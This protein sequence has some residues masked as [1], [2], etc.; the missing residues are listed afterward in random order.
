MENSQINSSKEKLNLEEIGKKIQELKE[1][2]YSN[3]YKEKNLCDIKI[4]GKWTVGAIVKKNDEKLL[5]LDYLL[6][7][8]K[9][10]FLI[11][12]KDNITYFRKK[13]K[14]SSK[15]RKC[16]R[17]DEEILKKYNDY[18]EDFININFGK[19]KK[20]EKNKNNIFKNI[21]PID[22]IIILRGKLYYISDEVLCYSEVNNKIGINLS[23]KYIQNSLM[24]IKLFFD[25]SKENNEIILQYKQFKKTDYE[26]IILLDE[27]YAIISF[28]KDSLTLLKRIFGHSY[29]FV[30]FYNKYNDLIIKIIDDENSILYSKDIKIENI[31]Q[32]NSYYK[33][34]YF[35]I[36]KFKIPSK[37]IAFF[38]DYFYSINGFDSLTNLIISNNNF[39]FKFLRKLTSIFVFISCL[40]GNFTKKLNDNIETIRNYID[41][42]INN[43]REEDIKNN[44]KEEIFLVLNRIYEFLNIDEIEK[45]KKFENTYL[46]YLYKCIY[47]NILEKQI[48]SIKT[49][50]SIALTIKYN[51]SNNENEVKDLTEIKDP[52]IKLLNEVEFA[53]FISSKQIINFLL[54]EKI[55]EEIIKNSFNLIL[56]SYKNNFSFNQEEYSDIIDEKAKTIFDSLYHKML[57][58]KN[59][60][61]VIQDLFCKLAPYLNNEHKLFIFHNIKEFIFN[62]EINLNII[63]FLDKFTYKCLIN[64]NNDSDNNFYMNLDENYFG[65]KL[66]WNFMQ[67]EYKNKIN[68]NTLFLEIINLCIKSIK[69]ILEINSLIDL[70]REDII[71]SSLEKISSHIGSTQNIILIKEIIS[72][73]NFFLNYNLILEKITLNTNI[74]SIIISDLLYYYEKEE[75]DK[76]KNNNIYNDEEIIKAH[77]SLIIELMNKKRELNWEF[78]KFLELWNKTSKNKLYSNIFYSNLAEQFPNIKTIFKDKIYKKIICNDNLFTIETNE[79]LELYKKFFYGINLNQDN[80]IILNKDLRIGINDLNSIIGYEKLWETLINNK[81]FDVQ[82][83]ISNLLYQICIGYKFPKKEEAKDYFNSFI[84]KLILNLKKIIDNERDENKIKGILNLVK[85]INENK[86]NEG[87]LIKKESNLPKL[88][89]EKNKDN[90]FIRIYFHYSGFKTLIKVYHYYPIYYIR[91]KVSLIYNIYP[92]IIKFK[93]ENLENKTKNI[94]EFDLC[95][96]FYLFN[97][98]IFKDMKIDYD[99]FYNIIVLKSNNPFDNIENNPKKILNKNKEFHK[100]LI[101]LSKDKDKIYS[102]DVWDLL[103]DKIEK[104]YALKDLIF[105]I[106]NE[107]NEQFENELNSIFDFNTSIFYISYILINIKKVLENEKK[108]NNELFIIN[109]V[110]SKIYIGKFNSMIKNYSLNEYFQNEINYSIKVYALNTLFY[111]L[112]IF[113]IFLSIDNDELNNLINIKIIQFIFEIFDSKIEENSL[114]PYLYDKECEIF[115]KICEL[116]KNNKFL[117]INFISEI[118]IDDKIKDT[119]L[120]LLENNLIQNKNKIITNKFKEFILIILNESWYINE[121][122]KNK[123]KDFN[124]LLNKVFLSEDNLNKKY[125]LSY[126]TE[127]YNFNIYFEIINKIILISIDLKLDFNYES[128]I[129]DKILSSIIENKNLSQT[130]LSGYLLLILSIFQKLKITSLQK[131]KNE[132]FDFIN[133]LYEKFIFSINQISKKS[134][135]N[136]S[137]LLNYLLIQNPEKLNLIYDSLLNNHNSFL[138]KENPKDEWNIVPNDLT[139]KDFV[140][141]K[142]LGCICYLNSLIQIFYNIIPFRESILKSPCKNEKKNVL[143]QLKNIFNYLKYYNIKY[144]EPI[145]FIENFDNEKLNIKEQMDMDEFFNLLL[146]KIENHL[147]GTFDEDLI[148][149]FFEGKISDD[150]IFKNN[151]RHHKKNNVSFYSIQLQVKGKK[152][153]K[154]SL[155]SFVEGELMK[156]ENCIICDICNKKFPA[157]KYQS[158]E[159]LPRILMF[160]LKRFEF[161]YEKMQ[162]IKINDKYEFP[163]ELDMSDYLYEKVVLSKNKF[164][165]ENN[166]FENIKNEF[167]NESEEN[168]IDEIQYNKNEDYDFKNNNKDDFINENNENIECNKIIDEIINN[169]NQENKIDFT[170]N[171][172]NLNKENNNDE[173]NLLNTNNKEINI[174][175]LSE[176]NKSNKS[177]GGKNSNEEINN[178]TNINNINNKIEIENSES[179]KINTN[180][181]NSNINSSFSKETKSTNYNNLNQN[182]NSNKYKLKAIAIHSGFADVGHYYTLIKINNKNNNSWYEFNDSTVSKFDIKNLSKEAFGGFDEFFDIENQKTQ[183]FPSNRN[184]YLLFYE[185]ENDF[186]CEKYDKINIINEEEKN[187]N[188]EFDNKINDMINKNNLKNIIFNNSYHRFILEFMINLFN[189]FFEKNVFVKLINFSCRNK[190]CEELENRLNESRMN[191]YGS[192]LNYY[193]KSGKIKLFYNNENNILKYEK[194]KDKFLDYF[195]FL[196]LYFF[197]IFIRSKEKKFL[198]GIIELIKFCLNYNPQCSTFFIEEF[199]NAN[200]LNEYLVNCPII[201]NK[202]IFVGLIFCAMINVNH[203]YIPQIENL[204]KERELIENE[205]KKNLEEFLKNNNNNNENLFSELQNNINNYDEIIF[206][207]D[208][209]NLQK[210]NENSLSKIL[211]FSPLL[212][213]L[214]KNILKLIQILEMNQKACN[215][216]YYILLRFVIISPETRNYLIKNLN[217]LL[218]LNLYYFPQLCKKF[219]IEKFPFQTTWDF[220]IPGHKILSNVINEEIIFNYDKKYKMEEFYAIFILFQ[221]NISES[222]DFISF[223]K[224]SID[225]YDFNNKKYIFSLFNNTN[226]KQG[227]L[228]LGNLLCKI[229]FNN[230]NFTINVNKVIKDIFNGKKMKI[231]S[232]FF[233]ILKIYLID[234]KD[235]ENF[236]DLRI[237]KIIKRIF[238][239]INRKKNDINVIIYLTDFI[240]YLFQNFSNIFNKYVDLFIDNFNSILNIYYEN[241]E[242]YEDKITE[243]KNIMISKIIFLI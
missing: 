170:E 1:K 161:N 191:K 74:F 198:L 229:C 3:T 17:P 46:N 175:E 80:F 63:E 214:I 240:I 66:I 87:S 69:R 114:N 18:F 209:F 5:I 109:F 213:Y 221:L 119:F 34:T 199:I 155:N 40:I 151:C 237:K 157:V 167:V 112:E 102:N 13:T 42:R 120:F 183:F 146:D 181:T 126:Q 41:N 26:D 153:L 241:E 38:I 58:N 30:E 187:E 163:L 61:R 20:K 134:Y 188:I 105:K 21:F 217:F 190:E 158:F 10:S 53:N 231:H 144:I 235:N 224:Y 239:T 6:S 206:P 44:P 9:N 124:I 76:I 174:L 189:Q 138:Y 185:K 176:D 49:L 108:K 62:S 132:P 36:E 65:L 29:F 193:I 32:K 100:I 129:K 219:I 169:N 101:D 68:D 141:I 186:N 216:L 200:I 207:F 140:G 37:I 72:D 147:K 168:I 43:F 104:N 25:Y 238:K 45:Q 203:N 35:I 115:Q 85:K 243:I 60:Q 33:N 50:D 166:N 242:L 196:I 23:L 59:I 22:Y 91:Y 111:L 15:K 125:N 194:N 152:N 93:F 164:N 73:S 81:N 97:D 165:N 184:A 103:K 47:S 77:L 56:I 11:K 137:S 121:E 55:D 226:T 116:I 180:N 197:N 156:G 90:K 28:L 86:I 204:K 201:D 107:Y 52:Y 113:D 88:D 133:F 118:L 205:R 54:Q 39:T 110:N 27:K 92:N 8:N 192:S 179:D 195:K 98:T 94:K 7:N 51:N 159:K 202:K 234:L 227:A 75:K 16:E 149:Y 123:F 79:D 12:D 154:E 232:E 225:G 122:E 71:L 83:N 223:Q 173:E 4:N 143:F 150:L 222:D 136:A 233:L 142:N 48:Y 78:D 106:V 95:D 89:T 171:K 127:V 177:N 236:K 96:D 172:N 131:L 82:K 130:F 57:I 212:S 64:N 162:K 211:E 67:E 31:C 84:E 230:E 99:Y 2:N 218:F 145:E 24:I 117:I 19:D 178:N 70:I 182:E 210:E 160:V 128:F 135:K 14:P 215:F 220:I 148:K 208:N 228:I 139:K